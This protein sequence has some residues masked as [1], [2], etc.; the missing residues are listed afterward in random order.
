MHCIII[1]HYVLRSCFDVWVYLFIQVYFRYKSIVRSKQLNI[2][3]YIEK[4]RNTLHDKI[5]KRPLSCVHA[6]SIAT[7][8]L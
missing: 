6:C 7:T 2:L 4:I 3:G 1:M 5:S 8:K